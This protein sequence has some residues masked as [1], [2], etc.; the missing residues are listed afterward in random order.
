MHTPD[1]KLYLNYPPYHL[2][3]NKLG[4]GGGNVG[5]VGG[6]RCRESSG[7]FPKFSE[8]FL[9]FPERTMFQFTEILCIWNLLVFEQEFLVTPTTILNLECSCTVCDD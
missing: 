4:L 8:K 2:E 3:E 5:E 6:A 1:T 7:K 9:E